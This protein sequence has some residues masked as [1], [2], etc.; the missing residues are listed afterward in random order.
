M[1][2]ID[3]PGNRKQD[4]AELALLAPFFRAMQM[5]EGPPIDPRMVHDPTTP[6]AGPF[7]MREDMIA[8]QNMDP[9]YAELARSIALPEE[10][11]VGD[12]PGILARLAMGIGGGIMG[13][14]ALGPTM[15]QREREN[16]TRAR[17]RNI[18]RKE[19]YS[20]QM[21]SIAS[22][23]LGEETR[24][25]ERK[26]DLERAAREREEDIKRD[27]DQADL[28][29]QL[30]RDT[31]AASLRERPEDKDARTAEKQFVELIDQVD[32]SITMNGSA[33]GVPPHAEF[34]LPPFPDVEA[35][36]RFLIKRAGYYAKSK[37][38]RS[39][40]ESLIEELV[41]DWTQKAEEEEPESPA[42]E[43]WRP[44]T[45]S[46]GRTLGALGS[47]LIAGPGGAGKF[48]LKQGTEQKK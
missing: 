32:Q 30:R 31:Y 45:K 21:T 16:R 37:E 8:G 36:K 12:G 15:I 7:N 20:Q 3:G 11:P 39:Y 48:L 27:I 44:E 29:R 24:Q 13:R 34:M 46:V 9:R 17:S 26:E 35:V 22:A 42:K 47:E 10:E 40:F 25:T 19:Q 4:D 23:A 43:V 5:K 6:G 18:A 38:Q 1:A 33:E 28:D 2:G 14:P 41:D